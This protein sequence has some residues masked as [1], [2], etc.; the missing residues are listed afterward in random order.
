MRNG[1]VRNQNLLIER[2]LI[3]A[4]EVAAGRALHPRKVELADPSPWTI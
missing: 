2:G 1:F 3:D 4:D